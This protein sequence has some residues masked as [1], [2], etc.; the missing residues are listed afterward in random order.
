MADP[1]GL[2]GMGG[3]GGVRQPVPARPGAGGGADG[4]SFKD[5]LLENLRKVD[6][7]QKEA[8]TAIEDLQTGKRD[9]LEG[10][11]MAAQKADTAFRMLLALRSRVQ[12]AYEEVKQ[13]RV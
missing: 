11:L 5:V 10:V 3:A 4:A 7:L 12:A 9:D 1:L 8:T 13:V 6:E 2:I